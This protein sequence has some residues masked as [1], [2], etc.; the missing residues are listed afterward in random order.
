MY[1]ACD[2]WLVSDLDGTLV[3]RSQRI[4]ERDAAAV[5]EFRAAGGAGM[6]GRTESRWRRRDRR[7]PS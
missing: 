3:D 2:R 4:A 7:S 5:A 1:G 6:P